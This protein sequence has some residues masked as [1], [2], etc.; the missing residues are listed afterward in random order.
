MFAPDPKTSPDQAL[1][2]SALQALAPDEQALQALLAALAQAGVG[3]VAG[4]ACLDLVQACTPAAPQ[5]L[6]VHAP[7]GADAVRQALAAWNGRPPCA[8]CLVAPA[9]GPAQALDWAAAGVHAWAAALQ[10][11]SLP[12]LLALAQARFDREDALQRE[13][14]TLRAQFD[15]RKWVDRAK[16]LLMDLR[17]LSEDDAFKLL[18]NTAM[19]TK[20][21]LPDVARSVLDAARWAEAVNRAGQLRMLSQRLVALAA[22]RLAQVDGARQRQTQ[23]L[24]RA[25]D[26]ID[27]LVALPLPAEAAASRQ[28]VV[29]AWEQLKPVLSARG[30]TAALAEADRRAE[31]LLQAA[32]TFTDLLQAQGGRPTLH[33]VN[34]CGRQRM[35]AQRLAKQAL[36]ATL[37]PAPGQAEA[38]HV[39]MDEFEQALRDIEAAPLSSPEIRQALQAAREGWLLLLRTLRGTDSTALAS[40]S[41][42]L[43]DELDRLTA[44]CEH[45]LQ[46]L[47][48]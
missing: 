6:I 36:V 10:A 15:E 5:L 9:T 24:R 32:D 41:E 34:L 17:S 46:L 2:A 37:M 22:Q 25:Q 7:Q 4:R 45:S 47:L 16:G 1:A 26:N 27:F 19:H 23:A 35:R 3:T 48:S 33:V 21:R 40:A 29:Q 30:G 18:R 20:L 14:A 39:L 13:L 28:A 11:D 31:L 42:R 12:T 44:C 38:L 8:L 43:L